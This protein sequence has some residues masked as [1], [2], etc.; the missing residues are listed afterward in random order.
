MNSLWQMWKGELSDE[1]VAR[2]IQECEYYEPQEASVGSESVSKKK[3]VR[4]SVVR[5]INAYDTNSKFIHDLIMRYANEANKIAFGVDI[6]YLSDIQYTI[7]EAKDEGFYDWHFDTFWGNTSTQDRKLSVTIQLS[8]SKDYTGGDFL[9][10]PQY[11]APDSKDVRTK[12]T[13]LVFPSVLSHMVAPVTKG[14]RKSLV[15]WVEGPKW[16]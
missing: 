11:E 8:D 16:K 6:N 12:G 10:D 4:R 5:W 2:I 14:T 15:A 9:I 3:E 1:E 7:Y 13:I